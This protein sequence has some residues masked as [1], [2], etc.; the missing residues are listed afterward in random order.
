MTVTPLKPATAPSWRE[1]TWHEHLRRVEFDGRAINLVDIGSG[2][3]VV[4]LHGLGANWQSWLCTIPH[5]AQRHRV[6]AMDHPGHGHSELPREKIS[7]P[8]FGRATVAV[9][10]ALEVDS[11]ALVGNSMGGFIGCEVAVT[12]PERVEKLA[13]VTAAALWNERRRARPLAVI[14]KLTRATAGMV[15]AQ[16]ELAFR[17]PRMREPALKLGGGILHPDR[18]PR[19]LAYELMSCA[20]APGFSDSL[21]GLYEYKLRDR[22]EDIQCPTLIVWGTKDPL[23]PLWHA[24]EYEALIPHARSMVFRDCGHV[25]QIEQPERFNQTLDEFLSDS[26]ELGDASEPTVEV[27]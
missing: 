20:G 10:D 7:I 17:Y 12:R 23:V 16:W 8:L 4:L 25:P 2:P 24:F 14:G 13:L 5:L 27:R 6:I 26:A 15:A 19:D 22:L 21:W 1:I 3:P 11:A 18:V 9:M